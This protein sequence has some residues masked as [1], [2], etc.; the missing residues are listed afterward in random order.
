MA[1]DSVVTRQ[2]Y[3][4]WKQDKCTKALLEGLDNTCKMI[5]NNWS[6][7]AYQSEESAEATASKNAEM[8]GQIFVLKSIIDGVNTNKIVQFDEDGE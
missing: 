4:G 8:L 3:I 2:E 5:M 7:K 1:Q 6:N